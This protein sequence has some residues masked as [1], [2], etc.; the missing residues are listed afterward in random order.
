MLLALSALYKQGSMKRS[1]F[2]IDTGGFVSELKL[3][4]GITEVREQAG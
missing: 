2:S 3:L 1:L 4:V